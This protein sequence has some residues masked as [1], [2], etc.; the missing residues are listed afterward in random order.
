MKPT[1]RT[2][3]T[4]LHAAAANNAVES[5]QV[6]LLAPGVTPNLSDR[7]GTPLICAAKENAWEAVHVLLQRD[8]IEVNAIAN[9]VPFLLTE[10]L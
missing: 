1:N 3:S 6:L 2:W 10:P 5:L 4:P 7:S 9:D 8:G